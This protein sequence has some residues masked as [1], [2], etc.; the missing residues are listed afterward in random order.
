MTGLIVALLI[1][2][3]IFIVAPA[4]TMR[5]GNLWFSRM[6]GAYNDMNIMFYGVENHRGE[7]LEENVEGVVEDK[8]E[9]MIEVKVG[10]EEY[11][12]MVHGTWKLFVNNGSIIV[13]GEELVEKIPENSKIIVEGLVM[14]QMHC[15]S[16]E[17]H[18]VAYRIIVPKE[19]LEAKLLH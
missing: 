6:H 15:Y 8:F 13:D 7:S 16:E 18:M 9:H 5:I 3:M 12:V 11:E 4:Y 19:S 10:E 1:I 14:G 17:A 2:L